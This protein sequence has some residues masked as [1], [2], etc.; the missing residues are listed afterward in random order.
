MARFAQPA[1]YHFD[2]KFC[3]IRVDIGSDHFT[4][5]S[6]RGMTLM[7]DSRNKNHYYFG[8]LGSISHVEL[9]ELRLS[10][11]GAYNYTGHVI[12]YDTNHDEALGK[13][14]EVAQRLFEE[15]LH[16][17]DVRLSRMQTK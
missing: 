4:V 12:D 10:S 5:T 3:V 7:Q 13:T 2:K 14:A 8:P 9:G 11:S 6:R 16:R 15:M 1:D 17:L